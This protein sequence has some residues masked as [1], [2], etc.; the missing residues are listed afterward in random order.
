MEDY[1]SHSLEA[2]AGRLRASDAF[3]ALPIK[4]FRPYVPLINHYL[5]HSAFISVDKMPYLRF[6]NDAATAFYGLDDN[7]VTAEN[8]G[9]YYRTMRIHQFPLMIQA[10][11]FF[12]RDDRGEFRCAVNLKNGE[13][14]YQELLIS[15][16]TVVWDQNERPAYAMVVGIP[17]LDLRWYEAYER[18]ELCCLPPR[19][20]E[21][22]RLMFQ[23]Y[24]NQEIAD[25]L[26]LSV[27]SVEKDLH[28]LFIRT[29]TKSRNELFS[30]FEAMGGT[31]A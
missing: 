19:S 4:D 5:T 3:A 31:P 13:G 9:F 27:K 20:A 14:N 23:G 21:A 2:I 16:K 6:N 24:T 17:R 12:N 15:M 30:K 1:L 25:E 28:Q 7:D 8:V 10:H 11:Q 22:G 26:E 29:E 18:F